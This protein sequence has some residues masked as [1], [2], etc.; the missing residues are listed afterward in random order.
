MGTPDFDHLCAE[1]R[2]RHWQLR[3]QIGAEKGAVYFPGGNANLQVQRLDTTTRESETIKIL[4][5]SPRCLEVKNGWLCCGGETGEF[6]AIPLTEAAETNDSDL[7]LD[8]DADARLPLNLDSAHQDD[9]ILSLLARRSSTRP[10]SIA[11][12]SKSFG[13]ERVNCITLWFPGADMR[14][15]EGAYAQPV[16]V[17]ANNDK[18]V[19]TVNLQDMESVD[20]LSYP[21]CVNRAVISPDGRLLI[22]I[23]DD[24]YL[25]IH[26][27]IEKRAG[28]S[29]L[30]RN[31][32]KPEYEWKGAGR[33][34][35]KSQRTDDDSDNRGSFA[36]CFSN[37]G[38]YLAVGTQYGLISIFNTSAFLEPGTDPLVTSFTSSRPNSVPGAVRDMAF[39]PGPLDLLAWTEDR[40]RVGVADIR[41]NYVAQQILH[42][43]THDEY[44]HI[45]ITDRG[46]IDP[47]LLEGRN[48]RRD[49]PT[50]SWGLGLNDLNL[51]DSRSSS[52]R[53]TTSMLDDRYQEPFTSAETM[54]LDAIQA[55]RR[56]RELRELREQR[57][58]QAASQASSTPVAS[59][60]FR[61]RPRAYE[62]TSVGAT[63]DTTRERSS[64]VTRALGDFV[65]SIRDH[66]RTRDHPERLRVYPTRRAAV[67]PAPRRNNAPRAAEIIRAA[68]T[69]ASNARERMA[70]LQRIYGNPSLTSGGWADLEALYNISVE[71]HNNTNDNEPVTSRQRDQA[72]LFG[73]LLSGVPTRDWDDG[74]IR[75][76]NATYYT[77]GD[78]PPNPDETA[79]LAWSEDGRILYVPALIPIPPSVIL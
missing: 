26:E 71:G 74:P 10:R 40:G 18:H 27:R 56:Q 19:I 24:P 46:S 65:D 57:E 75:R 15:H 36:A 37:T 64:S 39:C 1:L 62:G 2:G 54:V 29:S 60:S 6:A 73:S 68:E 31:R 14:P 16:A 79:G 22:A 76:A 38:R 28:S 20:E 67:P 42:L 78:T 52:T 5:F 48:D 69:E 51:S 3:S 45:I 72:A 32:D 8:L 77:R 35:L 61:D 66:N 44:D 7:R 47:R 9:Y 43:D 63:R 33:I 11:V 49:G 30:F 17:L 23:S 25:Y 13:K 70:Q 55:H 58:Q 41:S 34:H 12:K 21:D 4:S 53:R 59:S 50:S